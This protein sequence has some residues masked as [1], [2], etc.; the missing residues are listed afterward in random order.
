MGMRR[1]DTS[2]RLCARRTSSSPPSSARTHSQVALHVAPQFLRPR[3]RLKNRPH[4]IDRLQKR[5]TPLL[6]VALVTCHPLSSEF[7]TS[8]LTPAV[9]ALDAA[10]DIAHAVQ[11]LGFRLRLRRRAAS[12][13]RRQYPLAPF[14]CSISPS[15]SPVCL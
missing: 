15:S 4:R 6:H 1:S 9:C 2:T 3:P 7:A 10:L 11:F 12:S 14:A 5:N 13:C 8:F